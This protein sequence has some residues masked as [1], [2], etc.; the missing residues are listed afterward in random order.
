VLQNNLFNKDTG[1]KGTEIASLVKIFGGAIRL[2]LPFLPLSV[3]V[4]L[5]IIGILFFIMYF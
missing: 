5:I 2:P 1:T 3:F 4:L